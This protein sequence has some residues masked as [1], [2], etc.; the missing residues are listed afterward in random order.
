MLELDKLGHFLAGMMVFFTVS[1]GAPKQ[2][3]YWQYAP[4]AAVVVVGVGKEVYDSQ[5][6]E[7]HTASGADAM[8]TVAGGLTAWGV[9]ELYRRKFSPKVEADSALLK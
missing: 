5:H 9:Q 1:F 6:P 3:G 2:D 7:N 8:A 4:M